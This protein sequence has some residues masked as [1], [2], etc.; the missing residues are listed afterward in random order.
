MIN[1]PLFNLY[2][3]VHFNIDFVKSQFV[4]N[5]RGQNGY[6]VL[7]SL[8]HQQNFSDQKP[9]MKVWLKLFNEG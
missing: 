1:N 9:Q 8:C 2:I 4:S 5:F 6:P 3:L 7:R